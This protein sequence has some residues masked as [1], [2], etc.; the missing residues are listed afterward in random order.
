MPSCLT[1]TVSGGHALVSGNIY[2]GQN[3]QLVGGVNLKYSNTAVSGPI[4]IGLPNLSGTV[5]TFASGGVL[6][7]GGLADGM[8][9]IPGDT[10]FIPRSRLVSGIETVRVL[11]P[12]AAS[13]M[14]I[15]WEVF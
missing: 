14:R 5:N 9:M 3:F 10:Y 13:G 7:S 8:E 15:L 11:A 12:A 1:F 2:S 6:S 4:Y